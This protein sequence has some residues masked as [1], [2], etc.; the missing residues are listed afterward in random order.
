MNFCVWTILIWTSNLPV[1]F[2]FSF[3][4]RF[5]GRKSCFPFTF[6]GTQFNYRIKFPYPFQWGRPSFDAGDIFSMMASAFVALIE[7]NLFPTLFFVPWNSQVIGDQLFWWWIIIT[8]QRD[9]FL[10]STLQFWNKLLAIILIFSFCCLLVYRN[11]HCSCKIWECHTYTTICT[12]PRR[13]LAG[14]LKS[15][16]SCNHSPFLLHVFLI[17]WTTLCSMYVQGVGTFLD[18]IFG[19]GVGSTASV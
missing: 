10:K 19:T 4:L 7:V 5:V 8:A 14:C 1:S 18:G 17:E 6:N 12:Q 9:V 11:I 16:N 15:F 3:S 2:K 13:R